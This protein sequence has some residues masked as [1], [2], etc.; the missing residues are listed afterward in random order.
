M[1]ILQVKLQGSACGFEVFQVPTECTV[2]HIEDFKVSTVTYKSRNCENRGTVK[3]VVYL[4]VGPTRKEQPFP[5]H[6]YR[7]CFPSS[8]LLWKLETFAPCSLSAAIQFR[9][10]KS[11]KKQCPLPPLTSPGPKA[12][13]LSCSRR[14]YTYCWNMP[15][16]RV[17]PRSFPGRQTATPSRSTRNK[18]L[19]NK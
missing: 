15:N 17:N 1:Y 2:V 6:T 3:S 9:S 5:M 10:D 4:Y 16:K 18:T 13:P 8:L 19:S 7:S 12:T 14:S 11:Q